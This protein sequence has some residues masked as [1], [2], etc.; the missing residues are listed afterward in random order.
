MKLIIAGSR[1]LEIHSCVIDSIIRN[2]LNLD[3]SE[4]VSGG[5]AGVDNS[6]EEWWKYITNREHG[7]CFNLTNQFKMK[8]SIFKADWDKHGKAA[9]P[10]RNKQ[11]AEYSDALL[12]IWDGESRG[13]K[14]MREEMLKL[15]KPVYEIVIREYKAKEPKIVNNVIK[16]MGNV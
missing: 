10:I 8:L 5:A 6:G 2:Q 1:D 7:V 9:G 3:P 13:S 11:M 12:L 4:I 14:N 16:D 15:N